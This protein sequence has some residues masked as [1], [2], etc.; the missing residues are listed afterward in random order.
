MIIIKIYLK[1]KTNFK[2][3]ILIN[4]LKISIIKMRHKIKYILISYTIKH[5]STDN[6]V[7]DKCHLI[8]WLFPKLTQNSKSN[9]KLTHVFFKK[10][11]SY[12]SQK[13]ILFTKIPLVFFFS[14]MVF[15]LSQPHHLQVFTRLTLSSIHQ[16][17]WTTNLNL[18]IHLTLIYTH[19]F[20]IL[21]N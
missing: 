12:S 10:N 20:S 7:S 8:F 14:K 21:M 5:K 6:F 13:F 18:L 9:L 11:L 15:L 17:P 1:L 16:P 2:L 3:I 4:L 19:S